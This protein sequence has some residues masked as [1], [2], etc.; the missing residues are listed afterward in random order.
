MSGEGDEALT[1]AVGQLPT[2]R[3]ERVLELADLQVR[4][5][6]KYLVSADVFGRFAEAVADRLAV[7]EVGGRRV[8]RYES[9]Y[10]DSAELTAFHLHAHGRRRRF[11][12]RTRSYLDSGECM[13]E[14]KTVGGRGETIK[15]RLP[16]RLP[17]RH[18]LSEDARNFATARV[19]H[20][21]VRDL[22]A[23]LSTGYRRA[24]LVDLVSGSRLTC[25][26]DL[27]FGHRAER[28]HGPEHLVLVESKTVGTAATADALLWRLGQ[29]PVSLSK[30]CVGMALLHPWLPANRWN[31]VL[32]N[33]FGWTPER[34]AGSGGWRELGG[35]AVGGVE[36][37]PEHLADGLGEGMGA[38]GAGDPVP[39]VG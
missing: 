36:R 37:V 6:R 19:G 31:R 22:E 3:L 34:R 12:V 35:P 16:Y 10:F 29:R 20:P 32:R 28:R 15:D 5:D 4:V 39:A 26:V 2:L 23:V 17:D 13:L 9:V 11:K 1:G 8:F 33:D 38:G 14:V 21:A 7:L 24:T 18:R 25:D 30:Y 27:M